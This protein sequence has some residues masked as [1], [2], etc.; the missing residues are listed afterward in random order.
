M[1]QKLYITTLRLAGHARA[2]YYL[3]VLSVAESSFFPIPPDVMLAPMCLAKPSKVWRFAFLATVGSV[4]GGILGYLI[5]KFS[6]EY[7]YP[8]IENFGY[9]AAYQNAVN[10][11]N[12]WGFW[13]ILIAGFSPIPYKVF[14]IAAGALNMAFL[15]FI[16]G[17]LI[18]RGS[19]FYLLAFLVKLFGNNIDSLL[20]KYMDRIGWLILFLIVIALVV[21][22]L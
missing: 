12:N 22:N 21:V 1:F 14:T 17:S 19:R 10:W 18:G 4:L 7:I 13:A 16:I 9:S 2:S 8:L 6:F 15:P 5:G 20:N 11:F 3:F